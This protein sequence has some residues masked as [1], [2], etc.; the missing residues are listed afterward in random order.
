[1][2]RAIAINVGKTIVE[3]WLL[4]SRFN[5]R[6]SFLSFFDS[7]F[8]PPRLI[9][10]RIIYSTAINRKMIEMCFA[11]LSLSIYIKSN[12]LKCLDL[13]WWKSKKNSKKGQKCPINMN[14]WGGRS[15]RN[16][17]TPNVNMEQEG[18]N[19]TDP[20]IGIH[21]IRATGESHFQFK[22]TMLRY[23]TNESRKS[24]RN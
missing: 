3:N 4:I 5:A 18:K 20:T 15:F 10:H 7:S 13:S 12:E 11:L 8:R 2:S 24:I 17:L 14:P 19:V 16:N 22:Y 6:R 9:F 1:M 21:K 23:F